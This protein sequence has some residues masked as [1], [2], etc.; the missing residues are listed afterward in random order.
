MGI[1]NKISYAVAS[2]ILAMFLNLS[3]V[4]ME[5]TTVP[6]YIMAAIVL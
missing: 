3:D 5:D 4:R 6:F 2:L 1:S